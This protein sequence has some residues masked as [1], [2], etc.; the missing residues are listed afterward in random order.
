MLLRASAAHAQYVN[1]FTTITN[2]AITFTGNTLGLSKAPGLNQPGTSD[3]IGAFTTINTALQVGTFPAGTTLAFAQ[4]S[5]SA[6]LNLPAGSTVLYAELTWGGTYGLGGQDV[7]GSRNNS[8]TL[9][10][11]N[12]KSSTITPDPAFQRQLGSPNTGAGCTSNCFYVRTA[13][14]TN[15]VLAG[16]GGTYTVGGVPATVGASENTN[17]CAGWT[18]AV[19]FQDFSKPVRNLALF[20]GSELSGAAAASTMGFCTPPSG[21]LSGRL[22]VSA[23]EGDANKS[24]DTMLFG[25]TTPLATANQ[26]KGPNNPQNNFFASQINRD[27]GTLDTS[28]TFGTRNANAFT[29]TNISGGRQGWDIT[30][31]DV[32]AQL[33]NG[34]TQ[35]FAQGTTTSDTYGITALGLQIDVG[36]PVFPQAKS[37]DK[38]TTFVGDTLTYTTTVSNTGIV[39]ATNVVFTDPPPPGT[40]FIPGT[41][42]VDGVVQP[43]AN[44]GAGVNLGT[45]AAGSTKTVT[46]QVKVVAIPASPAAAQYDS[47]ASFTYQY[48][49][50]AGQ[51]TQNGSFTTNTVTTGIARI[52]ANKTTTPATV[53]AGV[54]LRYN[55]TIQNTGTAPATGV[56]LTDPIPVGTTYTPNSTA[57][58]GIAVPDVGGT[59]PFAL[60]RLVSS[61]GQPPG[62]IGP[63]QATTVIFFV[64]VDPAATGTITNT[65]VVDPDGTGPLPPFAVPAVSPVTSQAD[66]S[67][68]KDGP[69]RAVAGSNVV[70]TV[71]VT[72]Q[73]PS[74]ATS[75][76]LSDPTPPGLI[77]VSNG[78]DC[79]TAFPCAL[80]DLAPGATRTITTTLSVPSGYVSPDPIVNL[81]SV[82]SGTPDPAPGNNSAESSVGLNAPVANLTITKSNGA[83]SVVP[84]RTTTYTITVGNTGP[85]DVAGVQVT[86][87]QSAVLS[88]FTWTCSGSGGASCAA[89]SGTGALNTT[90]SLP[91][92][93]SATFLLT[94]TVA[95][96]GSW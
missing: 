50:C 69:D 28:G 88:N 18:L 13:K 71:T 24:G 21:K 96:D 82:T 87:P 70:F 37:V 43:G 2:G 57:E 65:A 19:V 20:V 90:V 3:A 35:A 92:G 73:G 26:L 64:L 34:Q 66:L 6:T 44:P 27:D 5:A 4:N 33:R 46:F 10:D 12:G 93:T 31:V 15:Q 60:G 53:V 1:R 8:I 78:G 63:N 39:D 9:V 86:D 51:P 72:N 22:A 85:S 54:P 56:T 91:A 25:A 94:A 7:S 62:V 47:T 67:V 61:F 81:A 80:G 84:G 55:I 68:T 14:V 79:T 23:M 17:N 52:V 95:T 30:N 36:A 42:K 74:V 59:M 32:S 89:A 16:G 38:A 11:P 77:F 76:T 41:F 40:T 45:L 75:A 58:D 49:S 48:V 29:A 83:T